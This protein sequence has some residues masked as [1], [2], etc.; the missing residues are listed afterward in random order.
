MAG[1]ERVGNQPLAPVEA[2]RAEEAARRRGGAG[3]GERLSNDA[4]L[5]RRERQAAAPP[6]SDEAFLRE[7]TFEELKTLVQAIQEGVTDPWQLTDLIFYARHPEMKG[8][9]LTAEHQSLL[10]EW[11][12]ISALLVHPTLNEIKDVI[13]ANELNGLVNDKQDL[14]VAFAAASR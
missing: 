3:F 13:G 8:V 7:R 2:P 12:Q 6:V 10:D 5:V 1:A 4:A 11:N 14:N 9:P